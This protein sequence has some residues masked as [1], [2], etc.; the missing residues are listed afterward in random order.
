MSIPEDLL[1][2]FLDT[3][4]NKPVSVEEVTF[5]RDRVRSLISLIE[6]QAAAISSMEQHIK[7]LQ[8]KLTDFDQLTAQVTELAKTTNTRILSLEKLRNKKKLQK[9]PKQR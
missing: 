5:L 3:V 8:S 4:E 1:T 6:K 7:E 9:K 2:K